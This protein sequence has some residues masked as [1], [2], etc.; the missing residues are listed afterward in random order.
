MTS[1]TR[2]RTLGYHDM[3]SVRFGGLENLTLLETEGKTLAIEIPSHAA[4]SLAKAKDVR[5][6]SPATKID[7]T[8]ATHADYD[9]IGGID[10]LIWSKVFEEKT[11]L[12][13]ITEKEVMDQIWQ[14]IK[15]AFEISRVNMT[16][17]LE[18]KDYANLIK[19]KMGEEIAI[20]NF[21][22]EIETF[23]RSTKHAP[24][25]SIAFCILKDEKPILGYSGDTAF[26]PE[27]IN[28]LTKGGEHPIIHEAGAYS[29]NSPSHTDIEDLLTLPR[30]TQQQLYL[31]HIPKILEPMIRK[32]IKQAN[33]PIRIANKLNKK[34]K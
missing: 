21:G 10:P 23:R 16:T 28:F 32:K 30:E 13:L 9:H 4:L 6:K 11:K 8:L 1:E 3:F 34:R 2:I 26:D 14:R 7:A 22:I 27:L 31:N 29:T 20:P 5:S 19:L 17:K 15:T 24:F 18:L 33:S 25:A 12:L